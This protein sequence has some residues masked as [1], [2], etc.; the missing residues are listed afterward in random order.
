MKFDFTLYLMFNI[1]L[2]QII[3]KTFAFP[4]VTLSFGTLLPK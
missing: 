3:T 2:F 4:D 1:I